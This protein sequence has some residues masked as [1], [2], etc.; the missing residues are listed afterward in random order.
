MLDVIGC[1]CVL[2][3]ACRT[4]MTIYTVMVLILVLLWK[5]YNLSCQRYHC[6]NIRKKKDDLMSDVILN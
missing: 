1:F 3:F 6:F 5:F 2:R 4:R